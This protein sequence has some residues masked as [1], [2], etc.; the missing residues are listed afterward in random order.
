M[1]RSYSLALAVIAA[2]LLLASAPQAKAGVNV[3]FGIGVAPICPYGYYAVP[4]YHCAPFGYYGPEWF[5]NGVFLGAGP[6]FHGPIGFRGRV[7][8]RYGPGVYK[9]PYPRRGERAHWRRYRHRNFRGS[10]WHDY[11]GK[12][13]KHREGRRDRHR[14]RDRYWDRDRDRRRRR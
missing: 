8:R 3:Y 11:R 14:D 1:K 2:L 9:G 13:H 10:T 5:V 12:V 6:W 7:N 4:P